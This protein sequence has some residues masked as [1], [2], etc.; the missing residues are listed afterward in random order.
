MG[1]EKP[2][3]IST[4]KN[5]LNDAHKWKGERDPHKFLSGEV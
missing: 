4:E 5:G 2:V 1:S 3:F